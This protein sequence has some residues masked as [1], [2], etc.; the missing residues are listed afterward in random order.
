MQLSLRLRVALWYGTLTALVVLLVATVTYAAHTRGHYDDVDRALVDAAHHAIVEHAAGHSNP[1][2]LHAIPSAPSGL[3]RLY[4]PNGDLV[5]ASGERADAPALDPRDLLAQPSTAA[6]DPIAGLALPFVSVDPGDGALGIAHGADGARWRTYTH[7]LADGGTL[8]ALAPIGGI[9]TSIAMFRRLVLALVAAAAILTLTAGFWMARR[10]LRPVATLTEA[11]REIAHASAFDR[12]VPVAADHDELGQ[13]SMT[14]NEMLASLEAAYRAEQRFVGDASHEL[15]APLTAIQ[16]NLELLRAHPDMPEDARLEAIAEVS[17]EAD[18]LTRLVGDLLVLARADAGATL[19][20]S[21]VELDR[22][23][24]DVFAQAR[25]LT[26][27]HTLEIGDFVPAPVAGDRD[28]LVQLVYILVHNALSYTPSDGRVVVSLERADDVARVVVRDTG[29]G[30]RA[31][32]LPRVFERFY[33]ADPA[34]SHD[35]G[36]TGLGLPIA[37]W[38]AEQHGGTIAIESA[39]S[40][41]TTVRVELPLAS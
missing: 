33:R 13:L 27:G 38:I 18:R 8:V 23:V 14:F 19:G 11:A 16:A 15:R 9:D 26:R 25:H 39:P 35:P 12:R 2:S 36:G 40:R 28:R 17:R 1:A 5:A 32:D 24:L 10:A 31:E 22:V 7:P 21:P 4:A 29:V 20:H 37:R 34:R 30:I 3:L 41:G 6:F